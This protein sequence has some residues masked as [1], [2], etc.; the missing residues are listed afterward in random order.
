MSF[1]YCYVV[2]KSR[3]TCVAGTAR[4]SGVQPLRLEQQP[5]P[6]SAP[7]AVPSSGRS[8]CHGCAANMKV[9]QTPDD[10]LPLMFGSS[11][12]RFGSKSR[13]TMISA[14]YRLKEERRKVL[15]ISIGKLKKIEDPESS[16]RRSVLINNTVK[17][18]QKEAREEKMMKQQVLYNTTSSC[19]LDDPDPVTPSV[20]TATTTTTPTLTEASVVS[21][22]TTGVVDPLVTPASPAVVGSVT[23]VPSPSGVDPSSASVTS[24]GSVSGTSATVPSD[25][26]KRPLLEDDCCDVLS[27]FYMPPTPR[28]LTSIDDEDEDD[29]VVVN[30]V[31]VEPSS[32][33]PAATAIGT[34]APPT[35]VPT[36]GPA[37]SPVD[38]QELCGPAPAKRPKFEVAIEVPDPATAELERRLFSC[39][40]DDLRNS[41]CCWSATTGVPRVPAPH[42]DEL[43][44]RFADSSRSASS[45]NCTESSAAEQQQQQQPHQYSCGHASIFG[46]IQSVVFHSLIASLES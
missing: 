4:A 10:Q 23:T 5:P 41:T 43:R 13:P 7:R 1:L 20:P 38:S 25:S 30:V 40:G 11:G 46:E 15:K 12:T 32:E 31:D 37:T 16:L 39:G 27:Q 3:R 8:S 9:N 21:P 33:D 35:G 17:R 42:A 18:L 28:M 36:S 19:F 26:R 22:M 24:V 2:K 6:A 34:S 14:K 44:L 29:D 45:G